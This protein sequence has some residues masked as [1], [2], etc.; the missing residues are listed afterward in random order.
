MAQPS[1]VNIK[2]KPN[3][4]SQGFFAWP[5]ISWA[6]LFEKLLNASVSPQNDIWLTVGILPGASCWLRKALIPVVQKWMYLAYKLVTHLW[7]VC[8]RQRWTMT[9]SV[10]QHICQ[11]WNPPQLSLQV[12]SCCSFAPGQNIYFVSTLSE[13]LLHTMYIILTHMQCNACTHSL[14]CRKEQDKKRGFSPGLPGKV[15]FIYGWFKSWEASLDLC[16]Q[17]MQ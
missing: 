3:P 15:R 1:A 8:P 2:I 9:L 13:L 6:T 12:S 5:I 10:A 7:T 4:Y 17:S 14:W 11:Y 16:E